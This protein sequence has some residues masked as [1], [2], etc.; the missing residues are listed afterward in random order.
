M[1]D[2]ESKEWVEQ[3]R[4][5]HPRHEQAVAKLHGVLLR[6]AIHELSRRR[7]QLGSIAGR[8]SKT[9]LSRPPTTRS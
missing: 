8:S 1:R 2:A 4:S 5:G 9:L 7:G 6:V 3:L